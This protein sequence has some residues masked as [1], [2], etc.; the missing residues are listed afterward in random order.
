MKQYK[1]TIW[2]TDICSIH[3][4]S[5]EIEAFM[6]MMDKEVPEWRMDYTEDQMLNFMDAYHIVE[7]VA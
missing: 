2:G 7:I 4:G 3:S 1:I 6:K 5:S